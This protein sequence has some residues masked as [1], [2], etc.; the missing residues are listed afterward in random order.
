M[1]R[2]DVEQL[3]IGELPKQAADAIDDLFHRFCVM[4]RKH[5]REIIPK[6]MLYSAALFHW[7]N[8]N[9]ELCRK[10]ATE[11]AINELVDGIEKFWEEHGGKE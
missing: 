10:E 4:L 1:G 3:N 6:K 9:V 11:E 5:G 2:S 7:L 8:V